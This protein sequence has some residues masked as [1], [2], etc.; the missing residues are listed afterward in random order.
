VR[1]VWIEV[2]LQHILAFVKV[3]HCND[4]L[5]MAG[6]IGSEVP[7]LAFTRDGLESILHSARVNYLLASAYSRCGKEAEAK[8]G[9]EIAAISS[10]PDQIGYA[11]LAA[12]KLP[13]FNAAQW[14][15]RVRN[16]FE[17]AAGRSETSAFPSYWMYAAG[18]LS[19]QMGNTQDADFRFRKALLLPDRMLAYH[20]TRLA[21]TE[22]TP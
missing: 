18:S 1:Q 8:A 4:A 12:Q 19:K 11:W 20:L 6:N 13:D 22:A 21:K 17:Q 5:K 15:G 16:S 2:Q 3:G 14:Q 9:Y 10:A 7:G